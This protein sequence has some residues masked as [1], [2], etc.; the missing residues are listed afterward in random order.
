LIRRVGKIRLRIG[1]LTFALLLLFAAAA[2]AQADFADGTYTA[3]Y[4]VL[5]AEDDS[6]SMANDYWEK[7]ATVIFDKGQITVRMTL[8]H[9]KWVTEFKVPQGGSYVATKVLST[10]AA[11]DK[12][13]VEFKAADLAQPILSKI[14]VTVEEID[15]DH[16]YTIRFVFKM[17]SFK[18]VKAAEPDPKPEASS[19]AEPSASTTP[20]LS[21][22]AS[23]ESS[24][25]PSASDDGKNRNGTAANNAGK[26]PEDAKSGAKSDSGTNGST[27]KNTAETKGAAGS[28]DEKTASASPK[29]S[30]EAAAPTESPQP[31]ESDNDGSQTA[32][33]SD[34]LEV[35]ENDSAPETAGTEALAAAE[36]AGSGEA[37]LASG[38][39]AG[40]GSGGSAVWWIAGAA[41][42]AIGGAV[43]FIRF[44]KARKT[45]I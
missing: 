16:D 41:V 2:N 36:A 31:A 6:A 10:D 37:L 29:P 14:H 40:T 4:V 35:P 3:E 5:K 9:S 11:A 1:G 33:S 27:I 18:L 24:P 44:A 13:V 34:E 17:D 39:E 45:R 21:P 12:R 25:A 20:E 23:K 26:T 38:D 15:Y 8:N 43:A 42:V 7:P 30:S 19:S 22:S 28:G 32:M